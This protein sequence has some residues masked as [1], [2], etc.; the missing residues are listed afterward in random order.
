ME[1]VAP[2]DSSGS[3]PAYTDGLR[4]IAGALCVAFLL[5]IP[6]VAFGWS[7]YDWLHRSQFTGH[8]GG[9]L[10]DHASAA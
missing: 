6:T 5:G 9:L 3:Y 4:R 2:S 1:R 8:F 7:S 10:L